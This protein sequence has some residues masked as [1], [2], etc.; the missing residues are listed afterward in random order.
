MCI[1]LRERGLQLVKS[2]EQACE[3]GKAYKAQAKA[4]AEKAERAKKMAEAL[5]ERCTAALARIEQL[6]GCP[7]GTPAQ[8]A[9]APAI[10]VAATPAFL[11][12]AEDDLVQRRGRKEGVGVRLDVV[13]ASQDT[14]RLTIAAV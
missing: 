5:R 2:Y 3:K 6:E 9:D 10:D 11:H 1:V 12:E 14:V 4:E 7:P 8:L 13:A